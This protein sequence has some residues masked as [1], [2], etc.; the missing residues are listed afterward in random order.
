MSSSLYPLV[1]TPITMEKPWGQRRHPLAVYGF[2]S[3]AKLGEV[4]LTADGTVN[5]LVANG[6]LAGKTLG[7]VSRL[8]TD[9]FLGTSLGNFIERP[10]PILLK[11]LHASEYLSVQVHPDDDRARRL[12]GF[13][14]GKNE[15]WYILN[16][17]P[18]SE[19]VLDLKPGLNK[20]D[21]ERALNTDQF[22][23]VL[24]R[25]SARTGQVHV[26]HAGRLHAVGPGVTLF[27]IQQ[28]SDVTYRF[29]DWHRLG[30]DGRPRSLHLEKALES[31]DL[32]QVCST[33]FTGLGYEKDG[34]EVTHLV[35]VQSFCL[36][37]WVVR[38]RL[39]HATNSL[40]FEILTA[41]SGVG[42]L[43]AE[44]SR[45]AIVLSPGTTVILP[46]SLGAYSLQ[47]QDSLTLLHSWM[48][49]RVNDVVC[50]LLAA[51][52]KADDIEQLGGPCRPNDLSSLL[53]Y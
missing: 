32:H 13:G 8:W 23:T 45:A 10:F 50:P 53:R 51:G 34:V 41:L 52:F 37:K 39:Y 11:F 25:T 21:L 9:K 15:A 18:S 5:S 49:D 22:E 31:M 27:E 4:W 2:A 24:G 44:T 17:E 28:N 12:E 35:A 46:A 42:T 38:Q 47:S 48:P 40:C 33:P 14:T 1:V 43:L 3:E 20:N 16:A 29:F 26:I 19:L 36:E 30:D 6:P 7:S